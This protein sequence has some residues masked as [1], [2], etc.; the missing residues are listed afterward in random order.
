M[1][2]FPIKPTWH[3]GDNIVTDGASR[4]SGINFYHIKEGQ[5]VK[6]FLEYARV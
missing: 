1:F 3:L 6:N 2:K 5:T 4:S